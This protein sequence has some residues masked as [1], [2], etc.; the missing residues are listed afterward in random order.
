ML[1]LKSDKPHYTGYRKRLRDR[2]LKSGGAAMPDYEML[3]LVLFMAQPRG[4]LKP[5]AKNLL[6][7]FG[8]FSGVITAEPNE[9]KKLEGVGEIAVA[10]L[11]IVQSAAVRLCQ[12]EIIGRPV[13]SSWQ[14]LLDYCRAAMGNW[15][16]YKPMARGERRPF[17]AYRLSGFF[18]GG[19]WRP[20]SCLWLDLGVQAYVAGSLIL[21]DVF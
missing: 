5:I 11:K 17:C 18:W 4:D 21:A 1:K 7:H 16:H 12:D 13:L 20:A 8:S 14:A 10:A 19:T 9:L 3:E 2:F 6:K 15:S